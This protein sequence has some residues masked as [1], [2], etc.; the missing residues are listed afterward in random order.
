MFDAIDRATSALR[1]VLTSVEPGCLTGADA[2]RM[3]EAFTE[4]E[5]IGAAGKTLAARRVEESNY[6]RHDGHRTAASWLAAKTGSGVGPALDTL[7]TAARLADLPKK[8]GP[9]RI[10]VRVVDV[11]GFEAEAI[12][13]VV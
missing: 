9:R 10:C 6:W 12:A 11:F 2:A 7:N 8:D 5:R 1:S 4:V 3:L 13:E